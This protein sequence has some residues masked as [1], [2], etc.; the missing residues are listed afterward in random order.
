MDFLLCKRRKLS[1]ATIER[2][3]RENKRQNFENNRL[4]QIRE[5]DREFVKSMSCCVCTR[6]NEV[7]GITAQHLVRD[8]LTFV[9]LP[10]GIMAESICT[11]MHQYAVH[12]LKKCCSKHITENALLFVYV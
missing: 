5:V 6:F 2:W 4:A 3:I 12:L 1:T 8:Q 10:L 9:A 7:V 11:N